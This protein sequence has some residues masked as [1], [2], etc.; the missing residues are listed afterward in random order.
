MSHLHDRAVKYRR[1]KEQTPRN[2]HVVATGPAVKT[3]C[4]LAVQE[5][6]GKSIP[7]SSRTDIWKISLKKISVRTLT[8]SAAT[9]H[10]PPSPTLA[11]PRRR[12]ARAGRRPVPSACHHAARAPRRAAAAPALAAGPSPAP[13]PAAGPGGAR[14]TRP[15]TPAAST[16]TGSAGAPQTPLP[17]TQEVLFGL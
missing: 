4:A 9:M 7:P 1:E 17:H 6:S 12:R 13:A 16:A 14:P 11:R 10:A 3:S 8:L 2:V 5:P 15:A